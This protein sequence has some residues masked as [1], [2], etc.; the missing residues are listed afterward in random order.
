MKENV[1]RRGRRPVSLEPSTADSAAAA[2]GSHVVGNM[3]GP[4]PRQGHGS[5]SRPGPY[6]RGRGK[7]GRGGGR[8]GGRFD[9]A[10]NDYAQHFVDTGLRPANFIRDSDV[11]EVRATAARMTL[12][13]GARLSLRALPPA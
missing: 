5:S 6:G 2:L 11:T 13:R 3:S 9:R 4:S 12:A 7:G 10:K 1:R 8:W